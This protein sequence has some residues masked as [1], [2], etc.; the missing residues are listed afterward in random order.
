MKYRLIYDKESEE[1]INNKV[2]PLVEELVIKAEVFDAEEVKKFSSGDYL[3]F[4]ISDEQLKSIFPVI[5]EKAFT[6]TVLPHPENKISC[7]AFGVSRQLANAVDHLKKAP[8]SIKTDVL[9]C[10]DK[11]VFDQVS[12]G[13]NF[14]T[15]GDLIAVNS[16][17]R[18]NFRQLKRFFTI[19]P[20]LL[21]INLSADKNLKTA[22][23]GISISEHRKS[24]LLARMMMEDSSLSDKKIHLFLISPRSLM[25]MIRYTFDSLKSDTKLPQFAAHI[26][27]TGGELTFPEGDRVYII[28]RKA[29]KAGSLKIY[30]G[31][32]SVNIVPG[33]NLRLPEKTN[34]PEEIFKTSALPSQ[35]TAK[36]I[37]RKSLPLIRHASTEEFKG[38][39][40]ILRDNASLKSSYL[41]LMVLSTML[42]TFGLFANSSPV[43]IGAMILAPLMS[44]IISL[45]MGA[46]RQDKS[47]VL[48]STYTILSGLGIAL[49]FAVL[50]TW[51]TPIQAAGEEIMSRTRPNLLD[52]G[53]AVISGIAG[54]YAHAREEIAKTLAGVAIA[55]ALIPPLAVAAIG[56]G[57]LDI[58]IFLGAMLLLVTNLAGIVLA[59]S[60]TFL[61][62]GFSPLKLAT[63]GISISL[64][65]V[66][67]LSIPLAFSF[68]EMVK[69]HSITAEMETFNSDV[70]DIRDVQV[71]RTKPLKIA[72]KIVS[73]DPLDID[74]LDELKV[75]IADQLG[76]EVELEVVFALKR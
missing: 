39:F 6:L 20:F 44:P 1:I 13:E 47:L 52:L 14:I 67:L 56:L 40:Q 12:V 10:N 17:F 18:F 53:V 50:L 48:T 31:E 3:L 59:A 32:E 72:L 46:L 60:F 16:L 58:D 38:L 71:Q 57:W 23:S 26:K 75:R 5:I 34:E 76:Q 35:A 27:T 30:I 41:V 37:A 19:K 36:E 62:L 8:E 65:V 28:D 21:D 11:I 9:Y 66:A 33:E 68:S 49:V 55:V 7:I 74:Q 69:I 25:E 2:L 61:M 24:S 22:V 4:Y 42:A 51:L 45:S 15:N 29:Y 73:D 64:I 63:K 70:I 54:A 43:V